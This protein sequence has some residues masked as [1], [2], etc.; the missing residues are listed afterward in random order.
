M[1]LKPDKLS[2]P[3]RSVVAVA[4]SAAVPR[5]TLQ[6]LSRR[7]SHSQFLIWSHS[8]SLPRSSWTRLTDLPPHV[9]VRPA[10]N[11][12]SMTFS[13]FLASEKEASHSGAFPWSPRAYYHHVFAIATHFA[14][15]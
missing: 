3:N 5:S 2:M 11:L 9:N 13:L 1:F 4:F 15:C 7:Q 10:F 12:T 14:D 8:Q 6:T